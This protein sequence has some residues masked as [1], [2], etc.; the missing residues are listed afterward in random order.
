MSEWLAVLDELKIRVPD[1][2][3]TVLRQAVNDAE[4]MIMDVCNRTS[5][6]PS[7]QNMWLSLS[8][9]Y[10]RRILAAGEKSRSEGDV[11]VSQAYSMEIPQDLMRRILSRRKLKQAVIANET[12]A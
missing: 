8:E 7:M 1:A 6:P 10:A 2:D 4:G 9:V 5:I 11:S 12:E 3:E